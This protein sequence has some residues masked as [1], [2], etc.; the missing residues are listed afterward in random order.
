VSLPPDAAWLPGAERWAG[1]PLEVRGREALPGGY[2]AD[3]V[4]RVDLDRA[5]AVVAVV[6]KAA[7][8]GE[9]AAMRALAVTPGVERPR[10]LA[11]GADWIVTPFYPG[12]PPPDAAPVADDVF[13]VLARVHEHWSGHPPPGVPVVDAAFWASLCE[14]V[15]GA[16]RGG[17]ART[18][19]ARFAATAD[20]LQGW[21]DDPTV[22]ETLSVL[23]MTLVHGDPHRGNLLADPTG[24][25]VIDWGNARIAPAGLD[26]GVLDGLGASAPS[27]CL[28]PA[29]VAEM[30]ATAATA[31]AALRA[32]AR[33]PVP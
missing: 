13:T 32:R 5:G 18:G 15:L 9:V 27:A 8:P 12:S 6:V 16:V 21:R 24:T 11:G 29:R 30:A 19:D 7:T 23:P 20:A 14:F 4:H 3:A 22:A 1:G 31:L 33:K 17:L 2:V 26:L 10:L 28:G 25:T